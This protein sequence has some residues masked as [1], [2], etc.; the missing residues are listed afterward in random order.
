MWKPGLIRF[1]VWYVSF[2]LAALPFTAAM[3]DAVSE[4]KA[5]GSKAID[6][7]S[8]PS[9][10]EEKGTLN[11]GSGLNDTLNENTNQIDLKAMFPGDGGGKTRADFEALFGH[12]S[13]L[14]AES[15]KR[16]AEMRG[17]K[18]PAAE[19]FQMFDSSLKSLSRPDLNYDPIFRTTDLMHQFVDTKVPQCSG[20]G[21]S[22]P[23]RV[24][25]RRPTKNPKQCVGKRAISVFHHEAKASIGAYMYSNGV[26]R[27]QVDFA[28]GT[29]S[30]L[31]GSSGILQH[32]GSV[33]K[34]NVDEICA[35]G[36]PHILY[37]GVS[38]FC[39]DELPGNCDPTFDFTV[40]QQPDCSNHLTAIIRYN[41]KKGGS[42]RIKQGVQVVWDVYGISEDTWTFDRTDCPQ[43]IAAIQSGTCAGTVECT[44]NPTDCVT[45]D[46]LT[47]CGEELTPPPGGLPRG[48]MSLKVTKQ[49][50]GAAI[51][52]NECEQFEK[53]QYEGATYNDCS[54]L[55]STCVRKDENGDCL[56][57]E[58]TYE[59]GAKK[60]GDAACQAA[61]AMR[62]MVQ[63][64]DV[65][66]TTVIE[67]QQ[68]R[69]PEYKTCE[70]LRRLT[71]CS[72]SRNL[73]VIPGHDSTGFYKG[74]FDH[75][76]ITFKAS[77]TNDRVL[78][79]ANYG[80]L[81]VPSF[82]RNFTLSAN[83]SLYY[84]GNH[85]SASIVQYPSKDNNWTTVVDLVGPGQWVDVPN[86]AY[87]SCM[88]QWRADPRCNCDTSLDP[89][90]NANC[91]VDCSGI[92][93][94]VQE[95]QC[96]PGTY[97]SGVIN[98]TGDYLAYAETHNPA[99]SENNP[100]LKDT[101]GWSDVNWE[102][103]SSGSV[104]VGGYSIPQDMLIP[105]YP[106]DNG[107]CQA[108]KV[109]Y[110]TKDYNVGIGTCWTNPEGQQVCLDNQNPEIYPP[111]P[112]VLTT[113]NCSTLA[114]DPKCR[115]V[116]A[117][118]VKRSDGYGGFTYVHERRYDCGQDVAVEYPK[119]TERTYHCPSP[120]QCM[121]E[122]CL[123]YTEEISQDFGKAAVYL[124]AAQQAQMDMNC[125]GENGSFNPMNCR[126]FSGHHMECK[127]AVGGWQDCCIEP[128]GVSL[129]NY[130]ELI[131]AIGSLDSSIM[132]LKGNQLLQG[133]ELAQSFVGSWETLRSPVVNAW[134]QVTSPFTSA[135]NSIMAEIL[136][137]EGIAKEI[138]QG[139]I[140]KGP[141]DYA[142]ETAKDKLL[143]AMR[144]WID[145]LSPEL[146]NFLFG[147]AASAGGSAVCGSGGCEALSQ[148]TAQNAA[149][150]A[151]QAA[152]TGSSG[153]LVGMVSSV[154]NMVM[155]AYAIYSI[156]DI[157]VNI[158][159]ECEMEEFQL[160]VQKQ[161][162]NCHYEG[163]YCHGF[164]C[165]E[166]RESYCCF[167]SP[168]ARIINVQAKQQL[169]GKRDDPENPDCSGLTINDLSRI[170]WSRIDLKEW[171]DILTITHHFPTRKEPNLENL[172]G[173]GNFLSD[174]ND[175]RPNLE[176]RTRERIEQLD[177]PAIRSKVQKELYP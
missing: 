8:L 121:G 132:A 62:D 41:D 84:S 75:D 79:G 81:T 117:R 162:R 93:P 56:V 15:A 154:L 16:T 88:A 143:T 160:G 106:G 104:S 66:V 11:L 177:I 33:P 65:T 171:L 1:I 26:V 173:S 163:S 165:I 112:P 148:S 20:N 86:P 110:T 150:A 4:A 61:L 74:C 128:S 22:S 122:S 123:N 94:T 113:D 144:G 134:S 137:K 39:P 168:L 103:T 85:T 102:C 161:L 82:T 176:E 63:D 78:P 141:I 10:D 125:D 13:K 107:A 167:N 80:W 32:T 92:P 115:F 174:P 48:C 9:L 118:I 52:P 14:E 170:D 68:V 5:L 142:M 120:L 111:K 69:D 57:T 43:D 35:S 166:K 105:L 146:S 99:E 7:L 96:P 71:K 101:D 131:L 19:A 37:A 59:C 77:W 151:S 70:I 58:D 159:W 119:N 51:Q 2:S 38:S 31:P 140:D 21:G 129:F 23:T 6:D 40:E 87:E 98:V 114:N 95:L 54:F 18:S 156:L 53:P 139:V 97:I 28:N 136:P 64:C 149:N 83:A 72:V 60:A 158:I 90:C 169:G 67:K 34:L 29:Y 30:I 155:V 47:F 42:S 138:A 127:Q 73:S 145:Q 153:G 44:A 164:L 133:V 130:I 126:V 124:H 135:Y 45:L 109:T 116:D 89:N 157:L 91:P 76:T 27:A 12:P 50:G 175:P 46:G 17:E 172:T 147:E 152:G 49:C 25:C 3:A 36:N 24:T 108:A 100:C 55:S